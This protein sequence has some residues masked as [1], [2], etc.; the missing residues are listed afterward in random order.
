M[1]DVP[2]APNPNALS[3]AVRRH[4]KRRQGFSA[5]RA[6]VVHTTLDVQAWSSAARKKR[7]DVPTPDDPT[8]AAE[9]ALWGLR[10]G[11]CIAS[12]WNSPN[13]LRMLSRTYNLSGTRMR[14]FSAT[15]KARRKDKSIVRLTRLLPFSSST[16]HRGRR[17]LVDGSDRQNDLL[18]FAPEPGL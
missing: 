17:A 14:S 2:R 11:T 7:T 6:M 5:R 12:S 18:E 16:L 10:R 4:D 3:I 15:F 1:A 8:R 13:T 9:C